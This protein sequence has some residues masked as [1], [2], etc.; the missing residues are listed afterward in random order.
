MAEAPNPYPDDMS[1]VTRSYIV[2]SI[3]FA[4][5]WLMMIARTWIRLH[6]VRFQFRALRID[7]VLLSLAMVRTRILSALVDTYSIDHPTDL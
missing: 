1:Q 4:I 2:T 7:D 6:S 3:F 5:A